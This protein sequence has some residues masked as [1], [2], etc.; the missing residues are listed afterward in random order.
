M[1]RRSLLLGIPVIGP[2][3]GAYR[4]ICA[5]LALRTPE[6]WSLWGTDEARVKAAQFVAKT[7]GEAV[8]WPNPVFIPDD[9]CELLFWDHKSCAIDD[10]SL[11]GALVEIETYF[12][13][14]PSEEELDTLAAGTFGA[15][16]DFLLG[17]TRPAR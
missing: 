12:N 7:L 9:P 15:Y 10:L 2:Q 8:E 14:S 17:R 4:D 6:C 11:V 13:V 3:A 1:R 16:V 5:Q